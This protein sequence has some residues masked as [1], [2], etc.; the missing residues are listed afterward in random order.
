MSESE[1]L[2][3][4]EIQLTHLQ[5]QYDQLNEVVIDQTSRID[6]LIRSIKM[7][8]AKLQRMEA[9]DGPQSTLEDEKPPHY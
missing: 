1:R 4:V 8:E 5:R 2:N 7:L 6:G 3:E 9:S